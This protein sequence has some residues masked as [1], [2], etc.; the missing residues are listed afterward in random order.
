[1]Y[2]ELLSRSGQGS[3]VTSQ[4]D[5]QLP[6]NETFYS[7]PSQVSLVNMLDVSVTN[8]Y[9]AFCSEKRLLLS[10]ENPSFTFL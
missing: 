7:D 8:A 1:M 10:Q 5:P 4:D 6:M 9:A 2:Q 3:N